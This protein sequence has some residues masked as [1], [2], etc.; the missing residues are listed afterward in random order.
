MTSWRDIAGQL[1]DEQVDSLEIYEVDVPAAV[2]LLDC[3]QRWAVLNL[4]GCMPGRL[5]GDG[6]TLDSQR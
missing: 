5:A 4:T 2:L 3:A 6:Y 1:T